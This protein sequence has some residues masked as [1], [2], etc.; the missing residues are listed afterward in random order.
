MEAARGHAPD[1]GGIEDEVH[2]VAGPEVEV[3]PE[4]RGEPQL[5]KSVPAGFESCEMGGGVEDDDR[6]AP[7]HGART[8]FAH[9]GDER[10]AGA[11]RGPSVAECGAPAQPG[12]EKEREKGESDERLGEAEAAS[13]EGAASIG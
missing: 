8:R 12:G 9:E 2:L 10:I 1:A 6:P 5:T 13:A 4:L 11:G 3:H 7:L